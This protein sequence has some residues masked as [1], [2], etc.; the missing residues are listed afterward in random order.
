MLAC[1]PQVQDFVGLMHGQIKTKTWFACNSFLWTIFMKYLLPLL[2]MYT[3]WCKNITVNSEIIACIYYCDLVILDWNAIL[4]LAIL[5]TILFNSYKKFQ[6][7]SLNHCDYN[8]V[9]FFA[10][11]KTF[12][13][14]LNLRYLLLDGDWF[15]F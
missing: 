13:K 15:C 12:Q 10:I 6:N 2:L 3:F 1:L 7:G 5:R 8:P 11:L 9:A 14:F 4:I